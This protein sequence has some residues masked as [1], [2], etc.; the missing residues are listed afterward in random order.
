M[1]SGK[2]PPL[3][4]RKIPFPTCAVYRITIKKLPDNLAREHMKNDVI[5]IK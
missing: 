3:D 2:F 4:W 5:Q 1:A